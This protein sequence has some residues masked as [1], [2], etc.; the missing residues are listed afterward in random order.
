MSDQDARE[1]HQ[2]L[3]NAAGLHQLAGQNE[4]RNGEQRKVVDAAEDPARDDPQRRA[5]I[6]PQAHQRRAA[7]RKG[8][9][10]AHNDESDEQDER[11]ASLRRLAHVENVDAWVRE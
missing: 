9:R 2:P 8:D 7:E 5:F 10:N 1:R 3:R 11:P 6:E 4:E